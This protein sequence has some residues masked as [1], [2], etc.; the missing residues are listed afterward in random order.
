M[1]VKITASAAHNQACAVAELT[2][3][4]AVA[5]AGNSQS[6]VKAAELAYYRTLFASSRSNN[7][8]ADISMIVMALKSLGVTA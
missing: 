6:A 1:A 5:A 3:Q 7:N 2:R 4:S 8:S